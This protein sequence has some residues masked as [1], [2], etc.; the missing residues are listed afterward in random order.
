MPEIKLDENTVAAC[1]GCLST[2]LHENTYFNHLSC[3]DV[4][5]IC[6]KTC[7]HVF[8]PEEARRVPIKYDEPQTVDKLNECINKL[9][10]CVEIL[11]HIANTYIK[12]G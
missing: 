1:P 8:G 5:M 3:R 4:T 2:D 10:E 11:D 9:R 6:C 7:G 12:K